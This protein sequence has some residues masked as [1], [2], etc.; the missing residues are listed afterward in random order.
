MKQI[1]FMKGVEFEPLKAEVTNLSLNL[2]A[3][4]KDKPTLEVSAEDQDF[5]L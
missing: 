5:I 2:A 3:Q 4:I 1:Q